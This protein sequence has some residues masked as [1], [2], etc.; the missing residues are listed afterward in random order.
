MSPYPVLHSSLSVVQ[1]LAV[2]VE[3]KFTSYCQLC[4]A[5]SAKGMVHWPVMGNPAH[6][7]LLR[8]VVSLGGWYM[9][10]AVVKVMKLATVAK[11]NGWHGTIESEEKDGERLTTLL[12]SRNDEKMSVL[13]RD[14]TMVK[15]RYSIF[16]VSYSLHCAS[17][18][19]ER[20]EGWPDLLKLFKQFPTMN[21]PTLVERYRRLPFSFEDPPEEIME[22]MVGRPIVWYSRINNRIDTD[23]VLP[24]KKNGKSENFRI[25]DIGHRKMFHFIGSQI[26]FRSV[27]LD[28]LIKVG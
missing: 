9:G 24:P 4:R 12:A 19:I 8:L 21:R 11:K 18:V 15:A 13:Y 5:K 26:G 17:L 7:L 1:F 22:K 23:F 16:S 27:L 25:A 28:T 2:E 6:N 14:N 10:K 3:C 20:L